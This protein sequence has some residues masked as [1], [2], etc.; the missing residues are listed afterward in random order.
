MITIGGVIVS[1][2][3]VHRLVTRNADFIRARVS[4]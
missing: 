3:P 4:F 2:L 1:N